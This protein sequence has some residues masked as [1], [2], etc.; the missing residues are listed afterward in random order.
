MG[1]PETSLSDQCLSCTAMFT[2]D[3]FC[4][5]QIT[6]DSYQAETVTTGPNSALAPSGL[7]S[8]GFCFERKDT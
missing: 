1:Y 8:P 2:V 7:A 3:G 5:G 6:G 4:S